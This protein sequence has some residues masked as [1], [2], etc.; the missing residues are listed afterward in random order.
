MAADPLDC[1]DRVHTTEQERI[2]LRQSFYPKAIW[3]GRNPLGRTTLPV[4]RYGSGGFC[5]LP[6]GVI[7]GNAAG[8][9]AVAEEICWRFSSR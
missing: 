7:S 3:G 8:T 4:D 5:P 6:A 2:A 1:R 9:T